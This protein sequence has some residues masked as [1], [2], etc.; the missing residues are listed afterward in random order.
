MATTFT[1]SQYDSTNLK[2]S[3]VIGDSS[4]NTDVGK[5]RIENTIEFKKDLSVQLDEDGYELFNLISELKWE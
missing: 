5:F 4:Q 2:N 3:L 1:D